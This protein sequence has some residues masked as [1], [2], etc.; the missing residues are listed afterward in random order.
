MTTDSSA[1]AVIGRVADAYP[2]AVVVGGEARGPETSVDGQKQN[3]DSKGAGRTRALISFFNR[4]KKPSSSSSGGIIDISSGEPLRSRTLRRRSPPP[5]P[6]D[7]IPPCTRTPNPIILGREILSNDHDFLRLSETLS[8][9]DSEPE[10]ESERPTTASSDAE[11]LTASP[12]PAPTKSQ[13]QPGSSKQDPT[14]TPRETPPQFPYTP[15]L[16]RFDASK[17]TR[18]LSPVPVD[19][20]PPA[21]QRAAAAPPLPSIL[22]TREYPRKRDRFVPRPILSF[23]RRNIK[24]PAQIILR[25]RS[26]VKFDT[27]NPFYKYSQSE[28]IVKTTAPPTPSP[29]ASPHEEIHQNDPFIAAPIPRRYRSTNLVALGET[30]PAGG[31]QT[32]ARK[33]STRFD[34]SGP[35]VKYQDQLK[36]LEQQQPA[37]AYK[38]VFDES[39]L[40]SERP[41]SVKESEKPSHKDAFLADSSQLAV[42]SSEDIVK[43]PSPPQNTLQK[44]SSLLTDP[45]SVTTGPLPDG[46]KKASRKFQSSLSDIPED[47]PTE[48]SED[49]GESSS[50]ASLAEKIEALRNISHEEPQ[51]NSVALAAPT[52]TDISGEAGSAAPALT[53]KKVHQLEAPGS[54]AALPQDPKGRLVIRSGQDAISIPYAETCDRAETKT[55]PRGIPEAPFIENVEDFVTSKQEIEPAI[56]KFSEMIAAAGLKEKI[57]DIK[58][59]LQMVQFLDNRNKKG[60]EEPVSTMFELSDTLYAKAS[61]VAPSEVYLWLGANVMLAYPNE[62]AI[63]MLKQKLS[64]AQESLRNCEE[65]IDFLRQQITTLEVNTSRMYN[66]NISLQR[67]EKEKATVK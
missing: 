1:D 64:A 2:G 51:H 44:Y 46:P 41:E 54:V 12:S 18:P 33:H 53:E 49:G 24:R 20:I 66:W 13:S 4:L 35:I 67:K 47:P 61:V 36:V 26:T 5:P 62:E 50:E 57:P 11:L 17:S 6:S 39:A 45:K 28:P 58:K 65:D 16:P 21:S 19:F 25:T 40:D 43:Q 7:Q 10:S 48:Q 29:P 32:H 34:D 63:T 23:F 38:S 14:N 15:A 55:N 8:D 31:N 22:K 56:R 60:D 42:R 27:A 59:T 30:S 3:N 52:K 37:K 9:S